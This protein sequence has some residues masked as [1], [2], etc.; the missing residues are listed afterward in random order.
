MFDFGRQKLIASLLRTTGHNAL[1]VGY[2]ELVPHHISVVD[3]QVANT[4]SCQCR[5]SE[6]RLVNHYG[7]C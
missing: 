6:S 3:C 5:P 1:G 2:R 7:V 4:D